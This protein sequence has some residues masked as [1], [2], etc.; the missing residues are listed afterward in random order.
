M[1]PV[2]CKT[3]RSLSGPPQLFSEHNI[4]IDINEFITSTDFFS[5]HPEK[6]CRPF[7][8]VYRLVRIMLD[9]FPTHI[10]AHLFS[11]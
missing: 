7:R 3:L 9:I 4:H 8:P 11:F 10:L 5:F 2:F 6:V 1:F